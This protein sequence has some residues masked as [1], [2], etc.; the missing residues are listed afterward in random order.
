L[1]LNYLYNF[2]LLC[3]HAIHFYSIYIIIFI[4]IKSIHCHLLYQYFVFLFLINNFGSFIHFH[5]LHFVYLYFFINFQEKK[6]LNHFVIILKID[7]L[8]FYHNLLLNI[9][10][11][12]L[13]NFGLRVLLIFDLFIEEKNIINF[14]RLYDQIMGRKFLE[15]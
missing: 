7:L 4:H 13:L 11:V 5:F 15:L 12:S 9:S 1:L 2:H 10:F 14:L 3:I 6:F 8:L